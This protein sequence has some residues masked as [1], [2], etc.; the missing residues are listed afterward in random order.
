MNLK[1]GAKFFPAL[2]GMAEEAVF[3]ENRW[4]KNIE[5]KQAFREAIG[6]QNRSVNN[7]LKKYKDNNNK[8]FKKISKIQDSKTYYKTLISNHGVMICM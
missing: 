5:K 4:A 6:S 3:F 2:K 8:K 1:V 7:D